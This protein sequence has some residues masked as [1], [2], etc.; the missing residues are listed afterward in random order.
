MKENIYGTESFAGNG[1][2]SIFVRIMDQMTTVLFDWILERMNQTV[3]V[4]V[5]PF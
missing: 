5:D 4:I 3:A 1:G 2:C